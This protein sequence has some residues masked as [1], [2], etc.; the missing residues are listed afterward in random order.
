LWFARQLGLRRYALEKSMSDIFAVGG[1]AVITGAASGIGRA[2]AMRLAQRGMRLCL[3]D[4]TEDALRALSSELSVETRIVAGDVSRPEDIARLHDAAYKA[5]GQVTLLMNNAGTGGGSTFSSGLDRWHRIIDVNL[6]GVINGVHRFVPSM[7]AQQTPCAIVNTG[8]KQGITNP[9]GDPAYAISKAGVRALTEQLAH[10]LR[11]EAG[12]RVSAHLLIPGWTYTN[13]TRTTDGK[14]P[15]GA[16]TAE[17]VVDEMIARVTAGD[18][19]ILCPDNAVSSDLDKRRLRWSIGD[20]T[21]NRPALSRWHAD[22]QDRANAWL[23]NT[24]N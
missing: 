9:P 18:F 2:A 23:A 6:W 19:Y 13:M 7:L 22:W 16:W 14:K 21:E 1:T 11:E 10:A 20:I 4:V 3:F 12:D 15:A 8:S 24:K 17:Q 5:F